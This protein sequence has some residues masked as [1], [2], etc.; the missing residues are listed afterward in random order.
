[1]HKHVP[2]EG[3]GKLYW[4]LFISAACTRGWWC[5]TCL[6]AP[7]SEENLTR[8][9][10][11]LLAPVFPS[12]SKRWDGKLLREVGTHCTATCLMLHRYGKRGEGSL[13][14]LAP[15]VRT[16]SWRAYTSGA[17]KESFAILEVNQNLTLNKIVDRDIYSSN[18][19]P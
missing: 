3:R 9:N 4:K 1:M 10:P 17:N 15:F 11:K 12:N 18:M 7:C 8:A 14:K 13:R 2:R 19:L 5:N 6:T 16:Q